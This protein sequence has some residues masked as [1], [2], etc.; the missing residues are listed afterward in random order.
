MNTGKFKHLLRIYFTLLV[1]MTQ[2]VCTFIKKKTRM[3]VHGVKNINANR[4]K[5]LTQAFIRDLRRND[6]H[7]CQLP[8]KITIKIYS[9]HNSQPAIVLGILSQSFQ[10][11]II[12][13]IK[14][15]NLFH[16]AIN[17]LSTG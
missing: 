2:L 15:T 6:K 1:H 10:K 3:S 17:E 14:M 7:I 16:L 13:M 11:L 12:A 4:V 5:P 8:V 9:R